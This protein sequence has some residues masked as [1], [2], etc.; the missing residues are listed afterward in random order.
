M[1]YAKFSSDQISLFYTGVMTTFIQSGIQLK[2]Y[3]IATI[4]QTR[5]QYTYFIGC[6]A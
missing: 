3:Y 1:E 4:T 5:K 2:N 6:T